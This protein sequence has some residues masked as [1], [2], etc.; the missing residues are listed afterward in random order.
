MRFNRLTGIQNMYIVLTFQSV[1]HGR[2]RLRLV[3]L[4]ESPR[5]RDLEGGSEDPRQRKDVENKINQSRH[6]AMR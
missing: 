5:R 3:S 6:G 1:D 4:L 2:C